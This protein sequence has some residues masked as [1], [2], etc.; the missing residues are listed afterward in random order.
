MVNL[1]LRVC[2]HGRDRPGFFSPSVCM[3]QI[4]QVTATHFADESLRHHLLHVLRALAPD[5]P[6]QPAS[7]AAASSGNSPPGTESAAHVCRCFFLIRATTLPCV[8]LL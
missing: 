1:S 6:E 2:L 4:V 3:P 7:A 5:E 8:Q